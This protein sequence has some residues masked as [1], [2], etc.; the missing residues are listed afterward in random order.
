MRS[1]T[2]VI[3]IVFLAAFALSASVEKG[4]AEFDRGV[5]AERRGDSDAAYTYFRD[6]YT[7]NPDN[8]Q[9]QAAFTRIRFKAAEGHVRTG[10]LLR[11]AGAL[12]DALSQFQTAVTID[13]SSS[14][15]QQEL[16]RTADM[17][18]EHEAQKASPTTAPPAVKEFGKPL[19]LRPL[20]NAPI[21]M[22]LTAN[23]DVVYKTIGKLAG[24]NVLV[25]P[26]Y[27]PQKISIDLTN[28]TLRE[29][30]DMVALESKTFWRPVLT[31]TIFIAADTG[32]KRK[33]LEQSVMRTFYLRNIE[34]P[35]DLQ[36]AANAVKQMLDLTRVQLLQGQ[37]ALI[38]RG[39]PDQLLLAEK[40]LTDFD[41]PRPEVMIEVAVMEVSRDRI[42]NLGNAVPT[43]FNI[44]YPGTGGGSNTGNSS[45]G[46]GNSS[47]SLALNA[48]KGLNGNAFAVSV[49][50]STLTLLASE[51][52]TKVLQNPQIRAI[53]DQKATLRIGDRVPVATGSY[54]SGLAGGG[55]VSP[56]IGTQF[57]YLDVGVNI[58][59]TPH[60]H[61]NGEV[62]LKMGLEISSVTG[63]QTIGGITEPQIGQRR[64]EQEAR[65]ADGE[66]NLLGGILQNSETQSLSG[67]PGLTQLPV[68][69]YL[70]GQENK[71]RSQSEIV[72]A[73]TP[74]IIRSQEITTKS[75]RTVEVGTG[76][77]IQLR[78][79][80]NPQGGP[81]SGVPAN[82]GSPIP[83]SPS[84]QQSVAPDPSG[85]DTSKPKS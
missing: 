50:G 82:P 70:F 61:S 39:T 56:L 14:I 40:V 65:L 43:S 55:S 18:R 75:L 80:S 53:N 78:D 37:D 2:R 62:T 42:R 28:V 5:R 51:S 41:Q 47:G 59:I 7:Q 79:T 52:N 33:E 63:Q 1:F 6:A 66:V 60:V 58:D 17:I 16:K 26:D 84:E 34:S 67:Y 36:E 49:P 15:A 64:I 21:S 20:S 3:T 54:Q 69:K 73:I 32:G 19:E 4:K 74:H 10:Q 57:T 77:L 72:F 22:F 29:A 11:S 12:A 68:L 30:L 27:K 31:N 35:T 81:A 24:L 71:E 85:K 76:T 44:G 8:S 46:S 23:T 9:Y 48:L 38:V 45:G 13:S 25:D 83:A